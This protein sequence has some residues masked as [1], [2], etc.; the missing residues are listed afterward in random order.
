VTA[1]LIGAVPIGYLVARAFGLGDIRQHGS[2]NIGATN[3]LRTVG[4]GPALATLVGD[5]AKGYAAVAAASLLSGGSADVTA[6][7]AVAAVIGNCWSAFLKFRGGKGMATALGALLRL[8]P[9]ATLAGALLW[10]V[11]AAGFRYASL[12][13]IVAAVAIPVAAALLGDGSVAVAA[14]SGIAVIIVARHHQN[15]ARL[16]AGTE[17]RLGKRSATT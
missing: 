15:I 11:V 8:V 14:A 13:S 17:S 7:G 16:C 5:I 6:A 3:V 10:L 1:Y 2:G 4:R 9:M 12:A